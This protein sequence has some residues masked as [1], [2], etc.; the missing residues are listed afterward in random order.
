[1]NYTDPVISVYIDLIKAHTGAIKTFYQGEPIRIPASNF[2]CAII[3]KRQ[4]RVGVH[5][6]AEDE[7]GMAL[8]IT[9]IT[10]VRKDL[11]SDENVSA[12]VAGVATLY[13][14]VEGRN[15]D[16]T[17]KEDSLLGI[18]RGNILVDADR[19]LRTDL[20]AQ[21]IVDY[22]LTL[23]DR[24]PEAWSIEARVDIVASFTQVR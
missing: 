7:H 18:L 9:V 22:G 24:A 1:M 19:G 17:L 23:R 16:L 15:A 10:D 3:S 5:T 21:T 13:D 11:T 14:L 2:P 12:A 6:N 4:T 20:G 8:S